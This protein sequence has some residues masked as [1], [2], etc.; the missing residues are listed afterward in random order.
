M[1]LE[2]LFN[3][4]HRR[5]EHGSHDDKNNHGH[6]GHGENRHAPFYHD[7]HNDSDQWRKHGDHQYNHHN[8]DLLNLS[9]LVPRLLANKKILITAGI[10]IL[11]IIVLALIIIVPLIGHAIDFISKSGLQGVIDRLLQ[12]TGGAK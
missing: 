1:D 12:L 2:D 10:V 4:N 7:H 8:D 9:H 5:R 11:A 3:R 6:Y